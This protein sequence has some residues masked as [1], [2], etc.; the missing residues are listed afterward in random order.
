MVINY[1]SLLPFL[2]KKKS[3]VI[4]L[5]GNNPYFFN[6]AALAIKK[7]VR[8]VG[9]VDERIIDINKSADWS[10]LTEEANSYSLFSDYVLLDIRFD[11]KTIDAIGKRIIN[12]YLT[13]INSRCVVMIQAPLLPLKPSSWLADNQN[14]LWV[15]IDPLLNTALKNW[16]NSHY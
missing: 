15:Q 9:E 3:P 4:I 14:V 12:T 11:K 16:I 13:N 5:S 6:E 8:D 10:L 7:S 2:K 1:Q